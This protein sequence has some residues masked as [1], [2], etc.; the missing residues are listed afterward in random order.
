[1]EWIVINPSKLK[2]MLTEPDMQRYDLQPDRLDSMDEQTRLTFRQIF[3]DAR[4]QT[5]FDT[6]GERL[7][8]Q[9]YTSRGGGCEIFV[10]KL[11]VGDDLLCQSTSEVEE[12]NDRTAISPEDT[13]LQR[14]FG[15]GHGHDTEPDHDLSLPYATAPSTTT[16]TLSF[17]FDGLTPLLAV[18]RRLYQMTQL[19][20]SPP[21]QSTAV[22]IDDASS[23]TYCLLLTIPDQVY[24][25]TQETYAF[26]SEYGDRIS[27]K[28]LSVYLSEHGTYLCQNTAIQTLGQL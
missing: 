9:L 4:K 8:V 10:T 24:F 18:C 14:L 11:G 6:A 26:L 22:Y 19:K 21:I 27:P 17:A 3:E 12:I 28:K 20:K 25:K 7:F 16:R 1:M 15:E 2:I 13:L 5:G 23:P